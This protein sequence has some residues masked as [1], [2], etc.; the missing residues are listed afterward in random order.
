THDRKGETELKQ[1]LKNWF[2]RKHDDI[3]S[4]VNDKPPQSPKTINPPK[5]LS[6]GW[7]LKYKAAENHVF[8][9]LKR[10]TSLRKT[11]AKTCEHCVY[12]S[13]TLAEVLKRKASASAFRSFLQSEFS[14]ENILFYLDVETYKQGKGSRRHKV[15]LKIYEQYLME[16]AANEVNIDAKTRNATKSGLSSPCSTTFDQAQDVIFRLMETDSFRRFQITEFR[17]CKCSSRA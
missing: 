12:S 3:V 17:K 5:S 4:N 16:G 14:D 1:N 2:N 8:R 15:A 6:T 7:L 10:S 11:E 13:Q 9:Q